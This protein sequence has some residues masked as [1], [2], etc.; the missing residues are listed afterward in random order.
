MLGLQ[1]V[2]VQWIAFGVIL[3]GYWAAFV[4][5][6]LPPANFDYASVGVPKD[7]PHLMSGFEAHWNKNSNLA[8]A[9]D[10]WFMNLFPRVKEFTHSA[11][12]YAT[13]SFIPTLGTM[14]LGAIAGGVL[15]SERQPWDKV[16]WFA[17]TGVVA[18]VAGLLVGW[19]GICPVV[20]R[21]WTP[22]WVLY[23]GGWCLLFI[24]GFYTVIDIWQRRT[25]AFPLIV[26]GSNS[27]VAYCISSVSM[28]FFTGF[29]RTHFGSRVFGVFGPH[30]E[31]FLVGGAA[32]GAVWL[33]LIWMHRR[34][35]FVKI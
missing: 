22:S 12:G 30:Y 6:P 28:G 23:S 31:T 33:L 1:S 24:A 26:F 17:I 21:I 10:T 8:W 2:R 25:W 18:L 3:V 14:I 9:F 20:K 35:I 32:V 19:S 29:F 7:W 34:K 13:L 4:G 16:R 11:G 5:H 15:R 27:I